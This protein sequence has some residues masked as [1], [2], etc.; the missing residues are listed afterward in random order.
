[1]IATIPTVGD[2]DDIFYDQPRKRIYA[3]GGEGATSVVQQ[4]DAD[5]YKK[6]AKIAT[7]SGARTG[8]F[9]PE[10][11]R[12]FVAVRKQGSQSAEI[13]IYELK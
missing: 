10:L 11:N 5:H 4:Q 1:V 7:V 8:F 12:L 6:I 13:R 2:C 3:T 9:S